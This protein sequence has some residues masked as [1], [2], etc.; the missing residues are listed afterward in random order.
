MLSGYDA[1][2]TWDG[3]AIAYVSYA[4]PGSGWY[5]DSIHLWR[6]DGS[7]ERALSDGG[8]RRVVLQHRVSQ[9]L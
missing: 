8:G 9:L 6:S 1:T 7:G 5:G 4:G 2:W 3:S